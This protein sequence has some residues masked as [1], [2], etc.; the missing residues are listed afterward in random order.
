[1][2]ERGFGV[3][4][5]QLTGGD[6]MASDSVSGAAIQR[7][8]LA[9]YLRCELLGF[10]AGRYRRAG[11]APIVGV[12]PRLSA[13]RSLWSGGARRLAL[14]PAGPLTAGG[15]TSPRMAFAAA[16]LSFLR[17]VGLPSRM[18]FLLQRIRPKCTDVA[19]G[20]FFWQA[21]VF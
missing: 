18:V 17:H 11:V 13:T 16:A 10:D 14:I 4:V 8:E 20:Q 3:V 2:S 12:R 1:M 15:R 6:Q 5:E 7:G 21:I 9:T 19:I